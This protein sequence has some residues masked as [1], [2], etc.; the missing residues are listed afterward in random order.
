MDEYVIGFLIGAIVG[1][2]FAWIVIH[3]LFRYESQFWFRQFEKEHRINQAMQETIETLQKEIDD[4]G[5][6]W[7]RNL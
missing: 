1:A 7:K 5:E 4:D 3:V 6:D 2:C